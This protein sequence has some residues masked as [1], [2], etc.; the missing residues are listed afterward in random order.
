MAPECF[1]VVR[2]DMLEFTVLSLLKLKASVM[3]A[4][5]DEIQLWT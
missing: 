3:F 2:V 4:E 1:L 5:A